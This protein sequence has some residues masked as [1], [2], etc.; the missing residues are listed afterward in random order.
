M[1]VLYGNVVNPECEDAG[2]NLDFHG[3][4]DR[5]ANEG[6]GDGRLDGDLAFLEV[7]LVRIDDRVC[8][9]GVGGEVGYLHL[10]EE[11]HGVAAELG[12]VH[13]SCM[14]EDA[15]LETYAAEEDA[16]GALGCVVL[17]VLA[18]VA[19]LAC[20]LDFSFHSRK[21]YLNELLQFGYKTI[22]AFL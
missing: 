3:V 16:L 21:F 6:L 7:G 22:V 4:A 10:A 13:D 19:L 11:A 15:L 9:L 18:E 8:H 20:F 5:F 1:R 2:R 17:K 14:L 12:G